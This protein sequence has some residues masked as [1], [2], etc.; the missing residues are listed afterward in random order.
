LENIF[1]IKTDA[2]RDIKK[3]LLTENQSV[4]EHLNIKTLI[5]LDATCSMDHLVD[6]TK[7]TIEKMFERMLYPHSGYISLVQ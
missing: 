3:F 2:N 6:K 4:I 5:L 7:K 1:S